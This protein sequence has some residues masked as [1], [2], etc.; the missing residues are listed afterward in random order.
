VKYSIGS[1][2]LA[3]AV[4]NVDDASLW[5]KK[6]LSARI[7]VWVGLLSFSL[8]IWQQPFAELW[9]H[10]I[11]LRIPRLAGAFACAIAS[12]YFIERPARRWLNAHPPRWARN[13]QLETTVRSDAVPRAE[14]KGS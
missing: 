3:L 9:P 7:V 13:K 2:C 5:V 8:Y 10:S 6:L 12:Y 11:L 14:V 4:G 1:A